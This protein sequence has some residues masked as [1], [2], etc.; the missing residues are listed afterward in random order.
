[1]LTVLGQFFLACDMPYYKR[2]TNILFHQSF[3]GQN[4]K[5]FPFHY[6]I[7][8]FFFKLFNYVYVGSPLSVL[9]IFH[10]PSNPFYFHFISFTSLSSIHYFTYCFTQYLFPLVYFLLST[11]FLFI[12]TYSYIFHFIYSC[13]YTIF[14]EFLHFSF[15]PS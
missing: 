4:I 9:Y 12:A 3:P 10:L 15:V 14:L 7:F 11:L 13:Y 6:F 1:M 5:F 2:Q 8:I